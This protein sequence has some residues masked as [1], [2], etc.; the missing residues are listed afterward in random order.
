MFFLTA[1]FYRDLP[2]E[3]LALESLE[4]L[5]VSCNKF[6]EVPLVLFSLLELRELDLSSNNITEVP[7]DIR[8]LKSL[9]VN[10]WRAFLLYEFVVLITSFMSLYEL[11]TYIPQ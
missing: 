4:T 10:S 5:D 7:L 6:Q 9:K 8:Y 2:R 3:L 1:F 11:V